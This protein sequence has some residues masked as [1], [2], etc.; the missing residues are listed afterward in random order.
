[1]YFNQGCP[2][3]GLGNNAK[4]KLDQH[5]QLIGEQKN[6]PR[7]LKREQISF[8]HIS[9]HYHNERPEWSQGAIECRIKCV[10]FRV[11]N[12]EDFEKGKYKVLEAILGHSTTKYHRAIQ[13][14]PKGALP[15]FW[16]R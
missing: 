13:S 10:D 15:F 16:R 2:I 12:L 4:K 1:M 8:F 3:T 11:R 9:K 5:F 7:F 14:H 6:S